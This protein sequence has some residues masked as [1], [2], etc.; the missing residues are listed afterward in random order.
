MTGW[1][2]NFLMSLV[3]LNFNS[4]KPFPNGITV[5][6][7]RLSHKLESMRFKALVVNGKSLYHEYYAYNLQARFC[8]TLRPQLLFIK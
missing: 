6:L 3:E 2:Q 5:Q 8:N 1:A 4:K 7:L